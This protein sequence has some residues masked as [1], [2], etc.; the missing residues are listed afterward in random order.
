MPVVRD[1]EPAPSACTPDAKRCAASARRRCPKRRRPD[2]GDRHD[3]LDRSRAKRDA[4]AARHVGRL[5]RA[6]PHA[7]ADDRSALVGNGRPRE[8]GEAEHRREPGH[9]QPL[10]RAQHPDAARAERRQGSRSPGRRA[11]EAGNRA[12]AGELQPDSESGADLDVHHEAGL[13]TPLRRSDNQNRAD[14]CTLRSAPTDESARI[15]LLSCSDTESL[16][17]K[18]RPLFHQRRLRPFASAYARA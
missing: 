4:G 8:S 10:R 12:A 13:S 18:L 15:S 9:R 3:I 11:A 7:R 1:E 5:V 14:F 16:T 2:R 17:Q 6:V